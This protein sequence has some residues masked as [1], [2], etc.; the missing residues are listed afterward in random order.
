MQLCVFSRGG[1]RAVGC[2]LAL[3]TCSVINSPYTNRLQLCKLPNPIF[4]DF[5]QE[6]DL[7][8]Y[9]KNTHIHT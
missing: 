6:K 1:Q 9:K 4:S 8:Y 2:S 5:E 3:N 7:K